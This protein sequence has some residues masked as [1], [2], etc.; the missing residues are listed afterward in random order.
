MIFMNGD[1]CEGEDTKEKRGRT[2]TM[3][4][5]PHP[6]AMISPQYLSLHHEMLHPPSA[7]DA[8]LHLSK[9]SVHKTC[10][11]HLARAKPR[12]SRDLALLSLL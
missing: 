2:F 9:V 11:T 12:S 3:P 4:S 10:G 8:R 7:C 6:A 5:M 1:A